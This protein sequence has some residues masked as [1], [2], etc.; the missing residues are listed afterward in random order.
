MR[1]RSEIGLKSIKLQSSKEFDF[2]KKKASC[3]HF[4]LA[5]KGQKFY[6]DLDIN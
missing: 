2:F 5:Y 1:D 6:V 4:Y 3:F